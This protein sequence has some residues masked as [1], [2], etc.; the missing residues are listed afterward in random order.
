MR[1]FVSWFTLFLAPGICTY[2]LNISSTQSYYDIYA[3]Y[4]LYNW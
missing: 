4:Y 3:T 1:K 2:Y